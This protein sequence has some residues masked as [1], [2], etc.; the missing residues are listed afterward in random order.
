MLLACNGAFLRLAGGQPEVG[1]SSNFHIKTPSITKDGP[2][3][4]S[5]AMPTFK[6]GDFAREFYLHHEDDPQTPIAYR[7]FRVHLPDG[8]VT[9][10]VTDAKG[11]SQIFSRGDVAHLRID[12]LGPDHE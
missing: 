1:G 6:Q 9:E 11:K 12:V 8:T 4:V 7:R 5:A 3:T 2:A 10:G